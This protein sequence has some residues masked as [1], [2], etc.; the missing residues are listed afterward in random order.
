M[1]MNRIG[2]ARACLAL[3][4][5][6]SALGV[7][8]ERA[9]WAAGSCAERVI[10]DWSDDGRIE[11]NYRLHCYQEAIDTVPLDLRDYTDAVATIERALTAALRSQTHPTRTRPA[12]EAIP[13]V[14]ASGSSSLSLAFLASAAISLVLLSAG[15]A[16]YFWRR[17]ARGD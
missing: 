9:S 13:A 14:D 5:G 16:G 12:S 8:T 11:T 17:R 10:S 4:V 6:V 3:V 15:A 7:F 1:P 2:G